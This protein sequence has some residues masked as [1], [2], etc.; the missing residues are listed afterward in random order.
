MLNYQIVHTE[1]NLE[2]GDLILAA[3][4][5]ELAA[6]L[7]QER[8]LD[9]SDALQLSKVTLEGRDE[10]ARIKAEWFRHNP[11]DSFVAEAYSLLQKVAIQIKTGG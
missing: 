2:N 9:V 5:R 4:V 11:I 8:W 7:V 3:H 1:K 6:R 10:R